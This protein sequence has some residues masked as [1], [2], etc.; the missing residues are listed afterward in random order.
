ML[1]RKKKKAGVRDGEGDFWVAIWT[2]FLRTA[3][4]TRNKRGKGK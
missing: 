1:D 2:G 3:A 4:T